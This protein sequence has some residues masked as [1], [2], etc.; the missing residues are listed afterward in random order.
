M[1][2]AVVLLALFFKEFKL[3]SFDP[4]FAASLGFPVRALNV[5]LTALIFLAVGIDPLLPF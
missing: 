3:L 5:L 2:A 4:A 1:A